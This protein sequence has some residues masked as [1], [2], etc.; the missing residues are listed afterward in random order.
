MEFTYCHPFEPSLGFQT[1]CRKTFLCA[2]SAEGV[3]QFAVFREK[4]C[5]VVRIV[6]YHARIKRI[7]IVVE[8]VF[9]LPS[10]EEIADLILQRL[11]LDLSKGLCVIQWMVDCK[12]SFSRMFGI[13]HHAVLSCLQTTDLCPARR[14]GTRGI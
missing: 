14:T 13:H 5:P 3:S 12:E 2:V 10:F 11:W 9:H 7:A 1:P 8:E 4:V 6:R